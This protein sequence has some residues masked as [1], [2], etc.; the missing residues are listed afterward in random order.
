VAASRS[1][2]PKLKSKYDEFARQT[3]RHR[4]VLVDLITALGGDADYVS[5]TARLVQ[6]KAAKLLDSSLQVDGLSDQEIETN[7]LENVLLAETKD[8]ADWHL[9]SQLAESASGDIQVA[10][11]R[12][13]DDVESEEDEHVEWARETLSQMCMQAVNEGKAPDPERWQTRITGPLPPIEMFHP[14]PYTDGLLEGASLPVWIETPISRS[15][16]RT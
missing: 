14:R 15:L 12:A 6:Y 16:A 8:H 2:T 13:V 3:A 9:L 5:P 4:Q 7:D 11:R 1:L 10:L